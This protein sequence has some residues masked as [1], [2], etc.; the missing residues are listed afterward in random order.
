MQRSN[1]IIYF[2]EEIVNE[3]MQS[4][5]GEFSKMYTDGGGVCIVR[6]YLSLGVEI[7]LWF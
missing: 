5:D 7:C 1:F 6:E 3:I 2:L 4:I